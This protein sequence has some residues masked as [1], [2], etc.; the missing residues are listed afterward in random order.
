VLG[1]VAAAAADAD[2]D[3]DVILYRPLR[4]FRVALPRVSTAGKSSAIRS[5]HCV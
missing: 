5:Y 2:D 4:E 1:V 3:D